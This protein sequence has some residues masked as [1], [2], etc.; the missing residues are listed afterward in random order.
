MIA[1]MALITGSVEPHQRGGFLSAN[2]S[3]QHIASGLAASGAGLIIDQSDSGQLLNFG[4]VGWISAAATLA[5]LWL[6]GRLR[7]AQASAPSAEEI[8]LA[9]AAEMTADAG[10]SLGA[11]AD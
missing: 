6:V 3:V 4:V 9:A 5:S 2:S 1:A 11:V 7:A 8:S 10:E